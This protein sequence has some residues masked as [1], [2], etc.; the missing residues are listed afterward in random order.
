VQAQVPHPVALRRCLAPRRVRVIRD[1]TRRST[2]VVIHQQRRENN[3]L[4]ISINVTTQ[5]IV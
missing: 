5:L 3:R 1:S 4:I 2:T